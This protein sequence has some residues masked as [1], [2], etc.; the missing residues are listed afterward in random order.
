MDETL[1]KALIILA[2]IAGT[3]I[4]AYG[5]F[6]HDRLHAWYRVVLFLLSSAGLMALAGAALIGVDP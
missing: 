1:Y 4:N 3:G 6:F 2:Y 5:I